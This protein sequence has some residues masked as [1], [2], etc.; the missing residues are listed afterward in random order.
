MKMSTAICQRIEQMFLRFGIKSVSMD[1]ISQELGISKKTLYKLIPNK[2]KLVEQI[3]QNFM[4][5]EHARAAEIRQEAR[6]PIHELVLIARHVTR[7]LRKISPTTLY[8]LRK[9]YREEWRAMEQ[10]RDDLIFQ[11]IKR[12]LN[13]GVQAGLYR[14]DI[15]IDLIATLYLRMGTYITD[16]EVLENHNDNVHLYSEF[17]RYHIRGIAT[18]TGMEILSRYEDLLIE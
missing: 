14:K 8:D 17:V 18:G 7:M 4:A 9:Y 13:T 11:E 5:E 3:L 1:D 10:E 2:G 6:D 15:N 16:H 12:N